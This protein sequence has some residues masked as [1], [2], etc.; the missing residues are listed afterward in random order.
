MGSR[1]FGDI[2]SEPQPRAE[3]QGQVTTPP[4]SPM[5]VP[6]L[7]GIDYAWS[8]QASAEWE[9]RKISGRSNVVGGRLS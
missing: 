5:F 7:S 6:K 3:V 9:N 2:R 4:L 1:S 8:L